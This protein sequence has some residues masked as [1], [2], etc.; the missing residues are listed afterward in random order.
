MSIAPIDAASAAIQL[1]FVAS[2]L[3]ALLNRHQRL[4]INASFALTAIA[5][6]LLVAAGWWTVNNALTGKVTLLL[7][8]PGLN[9]HMRLDPLS[10]FF[11]TVIGLLSFFVSLYSIGYVRGYVGQRSVTRLV[12]CYCLFL[13]GMSLVVLADD[14]VFFLICWEMMAAASYFLVMFEDEHPQ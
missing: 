7:G 4:L 9:F 12:V 8:L 2:L 10:G 1:L 5:S 3:A 11:L 13:A 14:A 6:V